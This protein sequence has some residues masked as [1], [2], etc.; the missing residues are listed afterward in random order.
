MYLYMHVPK[1][2][3]TVSARFYIHR[4]VCMWRREV[5]AALRLAPVKFLTQG[6]GKVWSATCIT[7]TSNGALE[8]STGVPASTS[9]E[10][11]SRARRICRARPVGTMRTG[12]DRPTTSGRID[13]EWAAT[14]DMTHTHRGSAPQWDLRPEIICCAACRRA[15][16]KPVGTVFGKGVSPRGSPRRLSSTP[17]LP[18][19]SP[20]R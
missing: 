8:S 15:H 12:C 16:N 13:S 18:Y 3:M 6:V 5:W 4:I 19:L 14:G 10:R 7:S 2:G 1:F 17:T 20:P 9:T 11:P